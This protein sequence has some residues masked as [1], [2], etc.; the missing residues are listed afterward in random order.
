MRTTRYVLLYA[1]A[2]I[3]LATSVIAHAQNPLQFMPVT[4]CRL[5]DTR[6]HYG[7][8]GPIPGGTYKT[9]NLPQLAQMANPPCASLASAAAYSLNVAVV[10]EGS[11]GYLTMWPAGRPGPWSPP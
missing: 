5:L 7:G 4:P 9:Y 6:T 1:L 10:P 8:G 3:L 11:L 2:I